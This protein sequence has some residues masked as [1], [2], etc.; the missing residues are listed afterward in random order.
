MFRVS[1]SPQTLLVLFSIFLC[2]QIAVSDDETIT[3]TAAAAYSSLLP[4]A[5][6][7]VYKYNNA[8]PDVPDPIG[9]AIGC[10]ENL[11]AGCESVG[12]G[13]N[14][15]YC[16]SD[17]QTDAVSAISTCV[18]SSCT[19]GDTMGD[20]ASVSNLYTGYCAGAGYP[21]NVAAA[22]PTADASIIAS[23]GVAPG[24]TFST[25]AI[26]TTLNSDPSYPTPS[27]GSNPQ[28]SGGVGGLS[29]GAVKAISVAASF[30][31]IIGAGVAMYECWWKKR[32]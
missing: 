1:T 29:S 5:Q 19:L 14:S 6:E 26:S 17:L 10:Y 3:I 16:R 32:K 15:C 11:N 7:C 23:N 28:D 27:S 4:C 8:C 18:L 20:F 2:I 12:W 31:A 21:V 9:N 13:K 22:A 24:S 25:A 30:A